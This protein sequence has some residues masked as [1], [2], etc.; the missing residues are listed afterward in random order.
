MDKV[1]CVNNNVQSVQCTL[2]Y[3]KIS[4]ESSTKIIL[5]IVATL[6][7]SLLFLDFFSNNFRKDLQ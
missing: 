6:Y 3:T 4:S 1:N 2:F 5:F 7:V